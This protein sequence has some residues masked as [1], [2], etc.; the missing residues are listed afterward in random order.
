MVLNKA[1]TWTLLTMVITTVL[2]LGG[3][4]TLG[5]I[6]TPHDFGV[7]A[8]VFAIIFGIEMMTDGGAVV[9]MFRSKRTDDAWLDTVWSF[10]ISRSLLIFG[11]AVVAAKPIAVF[12]E[13]PQLFGMMIFVGLMPVLDAM[14]STSL[15]M[16]IRDLDLKRY[17]ILEIISLAANYAVT[18]PI[19]YFYHT[20]WAL[21]AG[22]VVYSG[23]HFV[24]SFIMF[25]YRKHRFRFEPQALQE[26]LGF[27]LWLI[28]TSSVGFMLL[29][30]DKLIVGKALGTEALG[31]YSIAATWAIA[32]V[33]LISKVVMRIFVPAFASIYRED[34]HTGRIAEIRKQVLLATMLPIAAAAAV[35]EQII[36]FLY[37]IAMTEA[38]PLLRLMII[39]IWFSVL[40]TLYHHQFLVQGKSDR[41]LYAQITSII[42]IAIMLLIGLE[43]STAYYLAAVFVG[44]I[45][46]RAAVMCAM[47]NVQKPSG[48]AMDIVLTICFLVL[49]LVFSYATA[50]L[51][52]MAGDFVVMLIMGLAL[53][54]PSAAVAWHA[55]KQSNRWF[56]SQPG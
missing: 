1:M 16:S 24:L 37:P 40:D 56:A 6:L 36:D 50:W 26:L 51:A 42:F 53:V 9:S 45:A 7:A 22:G 23:C 20:A 5:H 49:V 14:A 46:V 15:N 39:G 44:G 43:K 25:P 28:L 54:V 31:I 2:R 21:I 47:A 29:Q 30:G 11:I 4:P 48:A 27:G 13:E 34:G 41:R 38:G 17:S 55:W 32:L 8:I 10:Q 18:I 3:N 33:D 19:A 12:F 35:G 52:T